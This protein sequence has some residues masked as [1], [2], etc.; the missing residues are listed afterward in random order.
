MLIPYLC[1]SDLE[2]M[3][4]D[5]MNL[6]A[7][8]RQ[9]YPPFLFFSGADSMWHGLYIT[10]SEKQIH[11]RIRYSF[12]QKA[13]K[14]HFFDFLMINSCQ[15]IGQ[16]A[17]H[18]R[19]WDPDLIGAEI[20]QMIPLREPQ[21]GLLLTW[22]CGRLSQVEVYNCGRD[23]GHY[24]TENDFKDIELRTDLQLPRKIDM[25]QKAQEVLDLCGYREFFQILIDQTPC[26]FCQQV[27]GAHDASC[28][29]IYEPFLIYQSFNTYCKICR[30]SQKDHK[31]TDHQFDPDFSTTEPFVY[32]PKY[33]S[34]Y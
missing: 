8:Q 16:I 10:N 4:F 33:F 2:Q 14:F 34:S 24:E 6:L 1:I 26:K 5:N 17:T 27:L 12:S 9:S 19:S 21:N 22:D 20:K 30:V 29:H 18:S 31:D 11:A 28:D 3:L 15:I 13:Q 23:Y 32:L 7:Q 25:V